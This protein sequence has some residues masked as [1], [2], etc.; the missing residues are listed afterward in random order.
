MTRSRLAF[1]AILLLAVVQVPQ[2]EVTAAQAPAAVDPSYLDLL[3]WRSVGPARG[4][5][6]VA[7]SGDPVNKFTFYQ[8]TTGGGVW[9]TE[10]G[11]RQLGQR[12]GRVLQDGLGRRDRSGAVR[13]RTSSMSAWAR[14]CIRGNVSHGDGVYKSTDAG[15]TWTHLGLENTQADR[16]PAR[17]PDQSRH[18]RTWRPSAMPGGRTR[19]AACTARKDGGKTWEKVLFKSE[20]RR[21]HRPGDG[22]EQP[23]H[24]VRRD[25]GSCGAIRGASAAAGPAAA[26]FKSTDGGDTWTD[27]SRQARPAEGRSRASIGVAVS[28]AQPEPRLGDRRGARHGRAS[29]APTTAARP[30]AQLS[31]NPDL[32]AARR[33]TTRTSSP[34]RRTPN[35]V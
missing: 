11:G 31:D 10:D 13:T 5:R 27:L 30:G 20:Q 1:A 32:H 14:A 17:A 3:R 21:R 29:S 7:V 19:S 15:K 18:R 16:T 24:P 33:G 2:I 26:L 6:V 35:T 34:T 22:P 8:G 4:G 25:P 28:P 9:K 12:L 23:A